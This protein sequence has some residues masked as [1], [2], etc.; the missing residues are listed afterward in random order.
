[1]SVQAKSQY[2]V[3]LDKVRAAGPKGITIGDL[4]K[5]VNLPYRV[6]HNVTWRMEGGPANGTLK[7]PDEKVIKRINTDRKVIYAV[8]GKGDPTPVMAP[9]RVYA[10]RGPETD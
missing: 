2:E 6:V 5:A 8:L 1:M 9:G 4:A 10:T 3:V 7:H